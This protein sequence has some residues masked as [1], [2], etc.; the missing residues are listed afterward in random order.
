MRETDV[1]QRNS[2]IKIT[3]TQFLGILLVLAG[4]ISLLYG[5]F[6]RFYMFDA[7]FFFPLIMTGL[8]LIGL[9]IFLLAVIEF[10]KNW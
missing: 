3:G 10:W 9:G 8:F 2:K 7:P 6:F 1:K 5:V 4:V